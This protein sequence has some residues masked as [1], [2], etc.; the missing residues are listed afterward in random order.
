MRG[1]PEQYQNPK[2]LVIQTEVERN[3][4]VIC[5]PSR[6]FSILPINESPVFGHREEPKA[7]LTARKEYAP[8]GA[9]TSDWLGLQKC[10][11]IALSSAGYALSERFPNRPGGV[12]LVI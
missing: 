8:D 1:P 7:Y 12:M 6:P 11:M 3:T 10:K 4:S 9:I 5:Y 2:T